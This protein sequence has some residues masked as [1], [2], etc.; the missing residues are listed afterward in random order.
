MGNLAW[1]WEFD[2]SK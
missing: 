2:S 1:E